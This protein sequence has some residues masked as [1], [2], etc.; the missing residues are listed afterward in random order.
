MAW[1]NRCWFFNLAMQQQPQ[2]EKAELVTRSIDVLDSESGQEVPLGV[3]QPAPLIGDRSPRLSQK[4]F[5]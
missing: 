4:L 3:P 5:G 1:Y 2:G